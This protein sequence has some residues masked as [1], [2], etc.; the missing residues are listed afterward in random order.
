MV[1][2]ESNAYDAQALRRCV[3]DLTALSALSAAWSQSD[4]REIADGLGLVL[5]RCLPVAI[6]YVRVSS[7]DGT[8]AAEAATTTQGSI[9]PER[10]EEIANRLGAVLTIGGSDQIATISNPVG[11]GTLRLVIIP[12]G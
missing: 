5:S 1:T 3:R 8:V 9:S 10:T 11:E 2:K 4:V 12:L 7:L 6:V